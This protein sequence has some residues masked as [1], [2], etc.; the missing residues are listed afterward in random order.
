MEILLKDLE[1]EFFTSSVFKNLEKY[2]GTDIIWKLDLYVSN[3]EDPEAYFSL[4]KTFNKNSEF[5]RVAKVFRN[6]LIIYC[7]CC[8][9]CQE[10]KEL[11]R[12]LDFSDILID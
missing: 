12:I 6:L 8:G 7:C 5:D 11:D 1:L 4:G 2:N 10:R 9:Y 3:K